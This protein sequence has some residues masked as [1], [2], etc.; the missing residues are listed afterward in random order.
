VPVHLSNIKPP[1]HAAKDKL[2]DDFIFVESFWRLQHPYSEDMVNHP[3]PVVIDNSVHLLGKPISGSILAKIAW[4]WY[5]VLRDKDIT[6]V[7]PDKKNDAKETIARAKHFFDQGYNF[8]FQTRFM[9]VAQGQDGYEAWDCF[10]AQ[11]GLLRGVPWFNSKMSE[12][13]IGIPYQMYQDEDPSTWSYH[14]QELVEFLLNHR[15]AFTRIHLLGLGDP[16]E[17][18][19]Y[20]KYKDLQIY[21]DSSAAWCYARDGV[22]IKRGG[23]KNMTTQEKP[24]GIQEFVSEERWQYAGISKNTRPMDYELFIRNALTL[25]AMAEGVI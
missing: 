7:V 3:G 15:Q 22:E 5:Y 16:G 18:E 1:V 6:V 12:I 11:S 23:W 14:R 13:T 20:S 25:R 24:V 9:L 4:L 8:P 2:L 19:G 10:Q 21:N 17:L